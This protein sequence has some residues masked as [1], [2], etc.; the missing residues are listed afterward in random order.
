M[1]EELEE[2][3]LARSLDDILTGMAEKIPEAEKH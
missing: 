3:Y 2:N 1:L